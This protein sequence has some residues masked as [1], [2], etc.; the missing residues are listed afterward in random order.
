MK[1]NEVFAKK[2]YRPRLKRV[3]AGGP[4]R[5]TLKHEGETIH[6]DAKKLEEVLALFAKHDQ[7]LTRD[8]TLGR[9][10]VAIREKLDK[11]Q[12]YTDAER[13]DYVEFW[14][15]RLLTQGHDDSLRLNNL[16]LD[17]SVGPYVS[18]EKYIGKPDVFGRQH[19]KP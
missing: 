15:D 2:T 18:G 5:L 19:T 12:M 7:I 9:I 11:R 16:R 10:L 17:I 8:P 1:L 6:S 3:A 13:R 14:F 4:F